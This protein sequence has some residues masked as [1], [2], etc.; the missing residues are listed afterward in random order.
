MI[1][2]VEP[3]Q[4]ISRMWLART[5]TNVTGDGLPR[6]VSALPRRVFRADHGE[7]V[8]K[9]QPVGGAEA[10]AHT[11]WRRARPARR[12]STGHRLTR[13][14]LW[15]I[16]AARASGARCRRQHQAAGPASLSDGS[17]SAAERSLC[18]A[19]EG[20]QGSLR[21]DCGMRSNRA[22]PSALRIAS[23]LTG[24]DVG[25]DSDTLRATWRGSGGRLGARVPILWGS[26]RRGELLASM[27]AITCL[28]GVA[29]RSC[30]YL[31]GVAA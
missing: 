4:G 17:A 12:S 2:G 11:A 20:R 18:I 8:I 22:Q 31:R 15:D 1:G 29:P 13:R 30:K 28:A 3:R 9:G 24:A 6:Q 19:L 14:A 25:G 10:G 23:N 7:T 21:A 16:R 26:E 27:A 5:A